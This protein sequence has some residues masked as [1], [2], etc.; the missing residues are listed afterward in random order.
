[1]VIERPATVTVALRGVVLRLRATVNAADPLPFP[2]A[3][4]E[5][6]NQLST[7]DAVQLHPVLAVTDTFA[8]P[9]APGTGPLGGATTKLHPLPLWV[10][11]TS[12]PAI[13]AVA[14]RGDVEGL[15]CALKLTVP[16][17]LPE[18]PALIVSQASA[19][20]AVQLHPVPA[21]TPMLPLPPPAAKLYVVGFTPNSHAPLWVIVTG[22]PA[23][24]AVVLR[25]D[26]EPFAC[27]LR[28]TVPFPL[29]LVP[30]V[31]VNQGSASLAVQ[32]HPV[33]AVTL[34]LPLPPPA[35]KL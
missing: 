11:V 4:A 3:P 26:A 10:T 12:W 20:V 27:A 18:A 23:I 7:S 13:V 19:S 15:A 35:A 24:V 9:P 22:C 2:L 8:V 6:L 34:T 1:M 32:V 31:I 14:V 30:A 16:F 21:V 17:P 33:P 29:P 28:V 5:M 25:D